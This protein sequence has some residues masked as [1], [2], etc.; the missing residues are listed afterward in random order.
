MRPV[1]LVMALA[2][3]GTGCG[4]S[5]AHERRP[6]RERS[7]DGGAGAHAK[8]ADGGAAHADG[9][10][11]HAEEHADGGAAHAAATHAAGGAA[12]GEAAHA[13]PAV[14][15]GSEGPSPAIASMQAAAM[16]GDMLRTNAL[17]VHDHGPA[18]FA[19]F[20]DAQHPRATVV[21]CADSRFHIGAMD[22][23]ADGD[24]FEIRNIGN[25]FDAT[26]GSIEYGVR[27]LHTPLLVI[28]GHV[29]CGAVKAAMGSTAGLEPAIRTEVG[30][31]VAGLAATP[32][33]PGDPWLDAVR[34]NVRRQVARAVELFAPEVEA[35]TLHVVGAIYDF[36]GD[37]GRGQG[38]AVV[39]DVNGSDAPEASPLL[40]LVLS[41]EP[42]DDALEA[43]PA[44]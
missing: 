35:G 40:Q 33:G 19:D 41:A 22:T 10:P 21:A 18:Y 2:L 27:H 42:L 24:V 26:A 3:V 32:A 14:A 17:F 30:R 28:M 25:Q 4:K 11:A 5:E 6:R 36:R 7:A 43:R 12:H 23:T 29:G 9:G 13:G 44:H 1:F 39:I 34:R 20:R 8:T 37:L 38:R 31:V 15:H 16:L